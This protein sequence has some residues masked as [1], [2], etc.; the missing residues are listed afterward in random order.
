MD[1]KLAAA[2]AE[3]KMRKVG[4]SYPRGHWDKQGRFYLAIGETLPCCRGIRPPS[5]PYPYSQ[6]RHGCTIKHLANLFEVDEAE[7]R[8]ASRA[9]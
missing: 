9:K 1:D 6:L 5:K 2:L 4:Q 8:R 7:L 3:Y